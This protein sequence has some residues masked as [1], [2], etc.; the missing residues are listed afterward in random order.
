MRRAGARI[1]NQCE[2][3]SLIHK[4]RISNF[5][6][7]PPTIFLKPEK[8]WASIFPV[9]S[10]KILL[11]NRRVLSFSITLRIRII[12]S[13]WSIGTR[14]LCRNLVGRRCF[15]AM[16]LATIFAT[17]PSHSTRCL[18]HNLFSIEATP[19]CRVRPLTITSWVLRY[20]S[21]YFRSVRTQHHWDE[22]RF[23]IF[24]RAELVP[25]DPRS[26]VSTHHRISTFNLG[27]LERLLD[28]SL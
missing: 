3:L 28:S 5:F 25:H 8:I 12:I 21:A 11:C 10:R 7:H 2:P 20:T 19:P 15:W 18:S 1:V 27:C 24:L 9:F 26:N 23:A 16:I 22:T 6:L 13:R 17:A 4:N 14:T